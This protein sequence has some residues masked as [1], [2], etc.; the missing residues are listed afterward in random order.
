[1][2]SELLH[3]RNR[4]SSLEHDLLALKQRPTQ[5]LTDSISNVRACNDGHRPLLPLAVPEI[6]NNCLVAPSSLNSPVQRNWHGAQ[7][8]TQHRTDQTAIDLINRQQ[9]RNGLSPCLAADAVYI[10]ERQGTQHRNVCASEQRVGVVRGD[11]G[12]EEDEGCGQEWRRSQSCKEEGEES[13]LWKIS[14]QFV[15]NKVQRTTRSTY[16]DRAIDALFGLARCRLL[17]IAELL[18]LNLSGRAGAACRRQAYSYICYLQ[19]RK[20]EQRA[21][22]GGHGVGDEVVEFERI[23]RENENWVDVG[24]YPRSIGVEGLD[25][26]R[27]RLWCWD[28][29]DAGCAGHCTR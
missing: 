24:V 14:D 22:E 26:R 15:P 1:M 28:S 17:L 8:S 11:R 23:E 3:R 12:A 2:R 5:Q 6:V 25:G 18:L 29:G 27:G 21:Q 9:K 7:P 4:P 16:H 10:D 20:G 19:D 13:R